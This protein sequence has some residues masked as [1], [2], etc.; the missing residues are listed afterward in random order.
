MATY[1]EV[2]KSKQSGQLPYTVP[3][4]KYAR[5]TIYANRAVANIDFTYI[6]ASSASG[7]T[8]TVLTTGGGGTAFVP[9]TIQMNSGD[10]IDTTPSAS[11]N[12]WYVAL[13]FTNP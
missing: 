6:N 4:G 1:S 11:G 3:A 10:T 7:G 12:G 9:L 13:E 5:V 2:P 8:V